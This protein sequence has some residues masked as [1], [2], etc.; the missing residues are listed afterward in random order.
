MLLEAE[1]NGCVREVAV[2]GGLVERQHPGR[3]EALADAIQ[4][5]LARKDVQ[6][7]LERNEMGGVWVGPERSNELMRENYDV[8][9]KYA[10]LLN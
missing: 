6:E 7:H 9:E 4:N 10:H 1:K 3:Y 5:A 2:I 8:F